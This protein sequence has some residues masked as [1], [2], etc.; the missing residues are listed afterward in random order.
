LDEG[1]KGGVVVLYEIFII[2]F[3]DVGV[4]SRDGNVVSNPDIAGGVP[5]D[6]Q[7]MLVICIEDEKHFGFAE[8]FPL[9]T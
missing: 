6:L 9:I 1:S 5:P 4:D 3:L 7:V 8:L 2:D